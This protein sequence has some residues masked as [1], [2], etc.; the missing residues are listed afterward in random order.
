MKDDTGR[1]IYVGKAKSLRDRISG[2][3]VNAA[4]PDAKTEIMRKEIVD[5]DVLEADSEVDAFLMEARLIKDIRPKYN[6][7]LKDDKSYPFLEI[8]TQDDFPKV[9]VTRE[10][11]KGSKLYGPF[12]DVTGL[13]QA[14]ELLQKIF[15]FCTCGLDIRAADKRLRFNRPCIL[16]SMNMC[17]APC[18]GRISKSEYA[19]GIAHLRRFLDGKRKNL[20]SGL[21]REMKRYADRMQF[22]KAAEVRD[23]LRAIEALA[24]R[25]LGERYYGLETVG[26]SPQEAIV[27]LQ[28]VFKLKDV[29]RTIEGIDIAN[30]AGKETVGSLVSFVD[31][32]P[33]RSGY[34]RFKIR[35]IGGIDDC[36]CIAEVVRRRY[37]RLQRESSVM[38]DVLLV[39]GGK[40]QLTSALKALDE[41]GAEVGLVL[42]I[43]KRQEELFCSESPKPIKLERT[44]PALRLLQYIRDEAHRFAQHY[45]HV[46]RR[47]KTFGKADLRVRTIKK[48]KRK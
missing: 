29:P 30:I 6:I 10:P 31:G 1:V 11:S 34:R 35:T 28:E 48:K 47:K 37:A 45:H 41:V 15:K 5:F 14:V 27:E 9:R 3:F 39:D 26:V 4:S 44:S 38:P 2:Y 13:H 20:I 43:A 7:R 21:E 17:S 12:T 25:G 40:G 8:T 23:Q 46:L 36:A 32:K 16:Y 42:S 22:E 18:A 33:C 24:K 19:K